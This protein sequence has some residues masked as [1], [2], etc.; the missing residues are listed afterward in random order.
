MIN[1]RL[2][3]IIKKEFI[4]MRRDRLTLAM[5]LGLPIIQILVFGYA[6]NTDVKNLPMVVCDYTR[7][8]ESRRLVQYFTNSQYFRV[9]D[10]VEKY[11]KVE[12]YI[13]SGRARVGI[14][15]GPDYARKLKSNQPVTVQVIVDASDPMVATS[16]I[17]NS[18]GIANLKNTEILAQNINPESG[19]PPGEL[20]LDIRVRGW[21]NPDLVSSYYIVPGIIGVIL[22][23]TMMM[24]TSMAIVRERETGTLEQLITT[25]IRGFE[26]MMGKLIPYILLGYVQ[27]T[28][29]LILGVFLFG[30][31]F[32]GSILL[33]YAL[34]FIYIVCYLGL[35]LVISTVARTQQQ[36]MQMSFFIFLPTILLSGY[37]FPVDGMPKAAQMI[38]KIL[39]L[40]YFLVILRGII[41][42]GIGARYL[43]HQIVPLIVFM[44]LILT[45]SIIRFKKSLD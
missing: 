39:P 5:M 35:G 41:L 9:I 10:N 40:T 34:T 13:A 24:I 26:L 20:P 19:Y 21:Y 43:W 11:E 37:M 7:T 1:Q 18:S 2:I 16:A 31:P 4:Q 25:P 30:V 44:V 33:L 23:M 27:V 28:L 32:R 36:A 45:F 29:A 17:S 12:S 22:T 3:A 8:Q 14:I 6:I 42:K 38:S 15:I